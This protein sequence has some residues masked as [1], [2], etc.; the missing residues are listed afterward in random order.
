MNIPIFYKMLSAMCYEPSFVI[1]SASQLL[2]HC[3]EWLTPQNYT[4]KF[5]TSLIAKEIREFQHKY[6]EAVKREAFKN[7]ETQVRCFSDHPKTMRH[8]SDV[9]KFEQE[10]EETDKKRIMGESGIVKKRNKSACI[11]HFDW[12]KIKDVLKEFEL[13]DEDQ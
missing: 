6:Y 12:V 7:D 3:N 11:Y 8:E 9:F 4:R 1:C 13:F 10:F 2:N 5:T